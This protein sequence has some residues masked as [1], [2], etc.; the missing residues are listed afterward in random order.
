MEFKEKTMHTDAYESPH[1]EHHPSSVG[2]R[3]IVTFSTHDQQQCSYCTSTM[4]HCKDCTGLSLH[5]QVV[6]VGMHSVDHKSLC[7]SQ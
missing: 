7:V 4:A 3:C 5:A 1:K 6:A 2:Q